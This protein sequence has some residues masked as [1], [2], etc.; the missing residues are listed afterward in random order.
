[1]GG[2][3]IPSS[4]TCFKFSNTKSNGTLVKRAVTSRLINLPETGPNSRSLS[5]K[6]KE[7]IKCAPDIFPSKGLKLVAIHFANSDCGEPHVAIMGRKGR[8]PYE[9]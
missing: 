3:K 5:T 1:M 6:S 9:F 7:C 8:H 2:E 4:V